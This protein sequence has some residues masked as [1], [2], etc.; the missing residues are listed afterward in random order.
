MRT[1]R[2]DAEKNTREFFFACKKLMAYSNGVVKSGM[3]GSVFDIIGAKISKAKNEDIEKAASMTEKE[4]M[5][6]ALPKFYHGYFKKEEEQCET[7]EQVAV[8]Q[9]LVAVPTC[10]AQLENLEQL[11]IGLGKMLIKIC[12]KMDR[13]YDVEKEMLECWKGGSK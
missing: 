9:Q 2:S 7:T 8:E 4:W 13:Q 10:Q 11:V 6:Y 3:L 12:E 5:D 1:C